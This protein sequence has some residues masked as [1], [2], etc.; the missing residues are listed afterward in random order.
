M[1]LGAP[2]A[3][4]AWSVLSGVAAMI[5][6]GAVAGTAAGIA[7]R[8]SLAVLLFETQSYDPRIMIPAIAST[9]AIALAA[10]V[11]SVNRALRVDPA[12][13]LRSD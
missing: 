6:P 9:I 11:P 5:G 7:C 8:R 3:S 1:A 12:A 2:A 10:A 4:I 13:M